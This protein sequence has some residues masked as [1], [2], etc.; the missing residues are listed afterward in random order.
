MSDALAV[1][2]GSATDLSPRGLLRTGSNGFPSRPGSTDSQRV[3]KDVKDLSAHVFLCGVLQGTIP[4]EHFRKAAINVA[5]NHVASFVHSRSDRRGR[6]PSPPKSGAKGS[7]ALHWMPQ[8]QASGSK[9]VAGK[10]PVWMNVATRLQFA[11]L[12]NEGRELADLKDEKSAMLAAANDF[13]GHADAIIAAELA[14]ATRLQ[15][16]PLQQIVSA[17]EQLIVL[18]S[19]FACNLSLC[20]PI[21]P[22]ASQL[23]DRCRELVKMKRVP[24]DLQLFTKAAV[25]ACTAAA[26]RSNGSLQ[27]AVQTLDRAILLLSS[28]EE[29]SSGLTCVCPFMVNKAIL[30]LQLSRFDAAVETLHAVVSNLM[31]CIKSAVM[32]E[33]SALLHANALELSIAYYNLGLA[34]D[35]ARQTSLAFESWREGT[36]ARSGVLHVS[37]RVTSFCRH[38][39]FL[40]IFFECISAVAA[41]ASIARAA[42]RLLRYQQRCTLFRDFFDE[43]RRSGGAAREQISP[44]CAFVFAHT[45]V[46]IEP[47]QQFCAARCVS[48]G[49]A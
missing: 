11:R 26:E 7:W 47:A 21:P 22:A 14:A 10:M 27:Q 35:L 5:L 16:A 18:A 8:K 45:T 49:S 36:Q 2:Q 37:P 40:D 29:G 32:R 28:S 46:A 1:S 31:V 17:V 38:T 39:G 41:A 42:R 19:M 34:H 15:N 3:A 20:E 48:C 4:F 30:L 43:S 24:A 12:S 33:D 25:L 6:S 9:L 13:K 23:L 44:I